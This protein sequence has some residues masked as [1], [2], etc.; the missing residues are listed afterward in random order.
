MFA[1]YI[2]KSRLIGKILYVPVD[3]NNQQ[4]AR[5]KAKDQQPI[6]D[7]AMAEKSRLHAEI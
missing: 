6:S 4:Q 3:I 2:V 7:A 1:F 5:V